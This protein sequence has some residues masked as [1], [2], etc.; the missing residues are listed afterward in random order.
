MCAA[1]YPWDAQTPSAVRR[2]R[3]VPR[4]LRREL[5][6]VLVRGFLPWGA[7][8][9]LVPMPQPPNCQTLLRALQWPLLGLALLLML[10]A[11]PW[12]AVIALFTPLLHRA[13]PQAPRR[14]QLGLVLETLAVV[15]IALCA[16]ALLRRGL[17]A[18]GVFS[19]PYLVQVTVLQAICV[20]AAYEYLQRTRHARQCTHALQLQQQQ[21][22]REVDA[23]R[24]QLLQAQVEPHFL[25]NT[26]AH[27]RRLAQTDVPAARATLAELLKVLA[28]ALPSLREPHTSL[29]R[30][31]TLVRAY[32]GLHQRRMGEARLRVWFDIEAGL[33]AVQL[34]STS[35][36][37]LVENAVKHGIAPSV[38]GGEIGVRAWRDGA[39]LR[40]DVRDTGLGMGSGSG[41]GT[42][43]ANLRARLKALHDTRA[44]LSLM[45]NEPRGLVAQIALPL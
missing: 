27:L 45:L 28:E 8:P 25:F 20:V 41:H 17:N 4:P 1:L 16:M 2:S 34:P 10:L 26:L 33:D 43:L 6:G 39:L 44:S 12:L 32:L 37:T 38:D 18:Q 35:V 15:V 40:I 7:A 19:D 23:A 42:G 24:L 3:S 31:L 9:R 21:M 29:L 36:L 22:A 5:L 13:L 30:E 11:T 14:R